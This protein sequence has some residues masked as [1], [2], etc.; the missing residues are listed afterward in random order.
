M[1][2]RGNVAHQP[3]EALIRGAHANDNRHCRKPV[4]LAAFQ[5]LL[6]NGGGSCRVP[7]MHAAMGLVNDHVQ[8]VAF[9]RCGI[10]QSLPDGVGTAVAAADK[11]AGP[12]ELLRVQ[13]VNH[14]VIQQLLVKGVVLDGN[15]LVRTDLVRLLYDLC[16]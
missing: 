8:A 7:V 6:H 15:A 5:E 2:D 16:L 3:A 13:E 9:F 14:A 11:T 4:R 10:L 1:A 12:A